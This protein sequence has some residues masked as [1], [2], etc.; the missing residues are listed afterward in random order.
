MLE[1][2]LVAAAAAVAGFVVWGLDR[3]HRSYG[4]LL[5]PGT[6]VAAAMILWIILTAF[7]LSSQPRIFWLSW[8]IP[9]LLGPAAAGTFG[10]LTGRRRSKADAARLNAVLR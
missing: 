10:W 2:V 7:G 5:I 4:V 9:V 6:A 3:R 1:L 8:L